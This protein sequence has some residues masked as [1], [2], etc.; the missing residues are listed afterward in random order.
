MET[1]DEI[2]RK[3]MNAEAAFTEAIVPVYSQQA[4]QGI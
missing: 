2:I 3:H 1:I 4:I